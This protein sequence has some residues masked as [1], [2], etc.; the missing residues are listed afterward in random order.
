MGGAN[1]EF[2][3]EISVPCW[4]LNE[5]WQARAINYL[6]Q[7][8]GVEV[9][10]SHHHFI[11]NSAHQFWNYALQKKNMEPEVEYQKLI[12]HVYEIADEY[13]GAYMHL[14]DEGWTI[15]LTSDHG[16]QIHDKLLANLGST[17]GLSAGIMRELGWTV[18][19]KDENGNDINEI[20]WKKNQGRC[21][22]YQ[23]YL[24]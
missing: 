8:R 13:I 12:D 17:G 19:Q 15:I 23:L 7:E 21:C 11:D 24:D 14:L 10:F 1:L 22:P 4:R 20:D 16:E 18:M 9:V 2:S 5:L 3:K 6:I